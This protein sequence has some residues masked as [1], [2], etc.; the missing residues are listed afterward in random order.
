MKP[1]EKESIDVKLFWNVQF[2]YELV[3]ATMEL[4]IFEIKYKIDNSLRSFNVQEIP[5]IDS[6]RNKTA[7]FEE[8]NREKTLYREITSR[9][10]TRS[11][12]QY[13]THWFYPY[14]GKFHPQ[15][16]RS[17]LNFMNLKEGDTVL[18]PFIGSGTTALE[19]QLL[20]INSI[21]ID[22]SEVCYL[23]SKVKTNSVDVL[24]EIEELY[25][26][27]NDKLL[28]KS[29]YTE[30]EI[31]PYL[32]NRVNDIENEDVRNFF[33]VAELITHSDRSRRRRKDFKLQ[34][35]KNSKKMIH[36]INDYSNLIKECKLSLGKTDLQI[37]DARKLDIPSHS[38]DGI[39]TSPPYSIAL[40]Y[41]DNDKHSFSVLGYDVKK[42]KDEF[43]GVRGKGK[44]KIELY[45]K[46]ME[47]AYMEMDRILK[48]GKYC[49]IIIGNA[50]VAKKETKSVEMTIKAFENMDYS[51]TKNI[52]KIIFGLY[53]IMQKENILI[54]QKN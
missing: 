50:T 40:D 37:A 24:P 16:I 12:N 13:L 10:I 17:L 48:P 38:I 43:I 9:N 33:R 18:D 14:K 52:D 39:I 35:Q 8:I 21:G 36:S 19:A 53:N 28:S 20:G 25:S 42:I 31:I 45:N 44:S 32:T 30:N 22:V 54:F 11:I 1:N 6:F 29:R 2:I 41:V 23:I 7:Y 4:D 47:K 27:L 15:M 3:L 49:V 34:F 5:D 51:I 26:D 46:D